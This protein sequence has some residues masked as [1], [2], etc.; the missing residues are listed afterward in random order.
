MV[1]VRLILEQIAAIEH[2]ASE[3]KTTKEIASLT[4]IPYHTIYGRTVRAKRL[5]EQGFGSLSGYHDHLA[6]NK[7]FSSYAE[8]Q[9]HIARAA[10]FDSYA[11]YQRHVCGKTKYSSRREYHEQLAHRSGFENYHAY[12]R[13]IYRKNAQL[14]EYLS[15]SIL[16]RSRLQ[17]C[18][19]TQRDL[20]DKTG[21][22]APAISK[23][24]R[25]YVLPSV[26]N[27]E[28]IAIALRLLPLIPE[29]STVI[30]ERKD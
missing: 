3:G 6:Q 25:G 9:R 26:R 15:C 12:V 27:W 28:K 16:L 4:G 5:V 8:Y 11:A 21:I 13:H 2:L 23:Y 30:S 20:S 24:A 10:G 17:Q 22:V 18:N 14:P 1:R 7:G 29:S 19:M